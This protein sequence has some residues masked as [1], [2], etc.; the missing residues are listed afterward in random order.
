M[1]AERAWVYRHVFDEVPDNVVGDTFA[2][3]LP[4]GARLRYRALD[5]ATIFL[6]HP[7]PL[8]YQIGCEGLLDVLSTEDGF[9]LL[10]S[11]GITMQDVFSWTARSDVTGSAARE[12]IM[13]ELL[14]RIAD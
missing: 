3:Q 6:Q 2:A 14:D 8:V 1:H 12:S 9:A 4:Q 5:L 10:D 7:D 11:Y 13:H